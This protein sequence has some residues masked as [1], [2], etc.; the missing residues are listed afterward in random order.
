[1][2]HIKNGW[3]IAAWAEEISTK[4][5][6]RTIGN[7]PLVLYRDSGGKAAALLDRCCH[8]GAAL[9]LGEVVPEGLQC[10]YHGLVFGTDGKCVRIPGQ[11]K[12]PPT[13]LVRS[14]VV[15][16]KD[17]II[18][19]WLGDPAAADIGQI[20]DYPYHNDH[21]K[22]PH[23]LGML[24]IE[25]HH[26][27]LID[28]LMDLTHLGFVHRSTI[29]SGPV[30]AYVDA[31]M[32][33]ER[34]PRGVKFT[35]WF[36]DHEP[37]ATYTRAVPF[38]GKVDRWQEF[39]FVAPGAVIQFTGAV[40]ANTGAY[41][42]GRRDGG[43]ALRLLHAST[44]E[45]DNSSFYFFSTANGH[46]Q[47]DPVACEQLF[48]ESVRTFK[49]DKVFIERQHAMLEKYPDEPLLDIV[50]DAAR[51]HARRH[52]NACLAAEAEVAAAMPAKSLNGS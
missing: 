52:V 20:I 32:N 16:E 51:V 2:S 39:E 4:P 6:A 18:W 3:Y 7:E 5:L 49:E 28:N 37:P 21:Q 48:T 41:D 38:K 29:G 8:R 14:Y 47:N 26:M 22:W 9:S 46:R 13:A 30:Q 19:I 10:G 36:L 50:S 27:L 33:T 12:I 1:M 31:I 24:R 25:G 34:T 35:R 17:E 23:K 43:V 42:Q 11:D 15:E 45:T 40:D 44:P